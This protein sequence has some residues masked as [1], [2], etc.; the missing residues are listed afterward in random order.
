MFETVKIGGVWQIWNVTCDG[1]IIVENGHRNMGFFEKPTIK[2][3][4]VLINALKAI[5]PVFSLSTDLS[6]IILDSGLKK[7]SKG[8]HVFDYAQL[9]EAG[10]DITDY[11]QLIDF[12]LGSFV[13]FK[14]SIFTAERI[15]DELDTYPGHPFLMR[16]LMGQKPAPIEPTGTLAVIIPSR[17]DVKTKLLES[18][19]ESWDSDY[20][21]CDQHELEKQVENYIDTYCYP[22]LDLKILVPYEGK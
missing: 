1:S 5:K 11:I 10:I 15:A 19:R 20:K 18:A 12:R 4:K 22:D 6:K 21:Q 9:Q 17:E 16:D 2:E 3:V 7:D 13:V 8:F 14:K